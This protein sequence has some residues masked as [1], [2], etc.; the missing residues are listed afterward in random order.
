MVQIDLLTIL[1][2]SAV[3][4]SA[5]ALLRGF[6]ALALPGERTAGVDGEAPY[7]WETRRPFAPYQ[8][9]TLAT[10]RPREIAELVEGPAASV[11]PRAEDAP[12]VPLARPPAAPAPPTAPESDPGR[13]RLAAR[14]LVGL[15]GP[16][17]APS[18]RVAA[19]ASA[20]IESL[21]RELSAPEATVG[22]LLEGLAAVDIVAVVP[23]SGTGGRARF[24]LTPRGRSFVS[25]RLAAVGGRGAPGPWSGLAAPPVPAA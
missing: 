9:E 4:L 13:L 11:V 22:R 21:A 12:A 17:R 8:A 14:L 3:A 6:G 15:E 23:G 20:T 25:D 19:N 18:D 16:S 24:R 7:G 10:D 1:F 5:A 2:G